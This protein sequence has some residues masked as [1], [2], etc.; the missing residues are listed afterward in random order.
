MKNKKCPYCGRRIPYTTLF[1]IKKSGTYECFR[2]KKQAKVKLSPVLLISFIAVFLCVVLFMILWCVGLNKA[3]DFT[4]VI[5]SAV[6]LIVYYFLT[7]FMINIVPLKKYVN[8]ETPKQTE[9]I[10]TEDNND[11]N[12]SFNRNAFDEIKRRKVEEKTAQNIENTRVNNKVDELIESIESESVV[13]IIENV[14]EAHSSSD[15]PLHKVNHYQK[16]EYS[17]EPIEE[18]DVKVAVPKRDRKPDGTKY[19]ANRRL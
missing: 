12:F 1:H 15:T 13:P 17:Y 10:L 6:V 19:T 16:N 14:S 5:I 18:D 7:P 11:Y 4:G 8:K 2:C 9:E 3:N